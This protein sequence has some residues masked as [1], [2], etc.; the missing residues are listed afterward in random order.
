MYIHLFIYLCI[1]LLFIYVRDICICVE[2]ERWKDTYIYIYIYIYIGAD[3]EDDD[4]EAELPGLFSATVPLVDMYAYHVCVC[5]YLGVCI[6]KYICIYIYTHFGLV[7]TPVFQRTSGALQRA[8]YDI[9]EMLGL[10]QGGKQED[11]SC[12][13]PCVMTGAN[14]V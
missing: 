9:R 2:R 4:A 3:R 12:Q 6:N 8:W 10:G 13:T 7:V 5:T 14:L 11:V 1:Y